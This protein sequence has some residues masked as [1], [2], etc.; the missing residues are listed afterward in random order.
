[1]NKMTNNSI[2]QLRNNRH[3]PTWLFVV[4]YLVML[5][6]VFLASKVDAWDIH[7]YY[8]EIDLQSRLYSLV[9]VITMYQKVHIDFI[10]IAI[11]CLCNIVGIPYHFVSAL[12]VTLYYIVLIKIIKENCS[13]KFDGYVL[14]VVLFATPIIWVLE[15]SRNLSAFMFFYC[16]LLYYY[17]NKWIVVAFF[18]VL[19][20]FTH[21]STLMYI[22][23]FVI[24]WLFRK[25]KIKP[26]IVF[27]II[28]SVF[29]YAFY[30]PDYL[31]RIMGAL[32]SGDVEHYSRHTENEA[33]NF[34]QYGNLNYGYISLILYCLGLSIVL[35]LLNIKQGFEYWSLFI[36]TA[37]LAFFINSNQG[38][39]NR[40]MML[41]PVFWGLNIASIYKSGNYKQKQIIQLLSLVG[42]FALLL[43]VYS[44]RNFFFPFFYGEYYN[45][46]NY[47]K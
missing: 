21:F 24:A 41:M 5:Y 42:L 4:M 44:L 40:C 38:L 25:V 18:L 28:G 30:V 3:I 29:V 32:L 19:G 33:I 22:P 46:I 11:L 43:F 39:M 35:L 6:L 7:R 45:S 12:I 34:I 23:L 14:F 47:N 16:A 27:I 26:W 17:R 37:L 20:V 8:D 36:L 10:Y 2:Q 31:N 1:M 13:V 15:I 9:S